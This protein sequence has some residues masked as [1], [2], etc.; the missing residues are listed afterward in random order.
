MTA[1]T[2]YG[3]PLVLFTA[4]L[5]LFTIPPGYLAYVTVRDRKANQQR[6]AEQVEQSRLLKLIGTT[7]FGPDES[8]WPSPDQIGQTATVKTLV[9][10][11]AHQVKPS[12]GQTV[13]ITVEEIRDLVRAQHDITEDL[14][15]GMAAISV[16][17]AEHVS[18]GHGGQRSW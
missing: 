6:Q 13:A 9:E 15:R 7:F 10:A 4:A 17:V 16:L 18:D 5:V 2:S 12:N 8:K 11:V 3:D 1:A 14:Q